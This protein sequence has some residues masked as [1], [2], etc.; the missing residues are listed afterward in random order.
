MA[1]IYLWDKFGWGLNFLPSTSR[2]FL[3]QLF[4]PS[5]SDSLITADNLTFR[6]RDTTTLTSLNNLSDVLIVAVQDGE[7]LTYREGVWVNE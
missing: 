5:G 7:E 4:I 1:S 6:V 3:T 2:A